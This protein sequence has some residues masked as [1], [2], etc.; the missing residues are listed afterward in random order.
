MKQ[1]THK[2]VEPTPPI[3]DQLRQA[4]VLVVEHLWEDEEAD[5]NANPSEKH[6][7]SALKVIAGWLDGPKSC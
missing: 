3:P 4:L 6:I 1:A 7:F 2:Q 5:Y